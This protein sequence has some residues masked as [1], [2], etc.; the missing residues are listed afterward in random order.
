MFKR[1]LSITLAMIIAMSTFSTIS[2][3]ATQNTPANIKNTQLSAQGENSL[4]NMI[5]DELD[6]AMSQDLTSA[7]FSITGLT[8][9]GHTATVDYMSA[10]DCTI[11]VAL[12]DEK[13][14][15]M[16]ASGKSSVTSENDVATIN[17]EATLMPQY[18]VATAYML[19]KNNAPLT[20]EFTTELYTEDI[21]KVKEMKAT[22]FDEEL[23]LNLDDSD[24]TN[25]AVYSEDTKVLE[26][27]ENF[28]IPERI[29]DENGIYV[30]SNADEELKSLKKGD[31]FVYEYSI[32]NIFIFEVDTIEVNGDTV[33]ITEGEA[34]LEEVFDYVKIEAKQDT[35]DC[36][37]NMDG[38]DDDV[39]LIDDTSPLP[40]KGPASVG[41]EGDVTFEPEDIKLKLLGDADGKNIKITGDV[42]FGATATLEFYITLGKSYV[43][44]SIDY[45][46]DYTLSL[47]VKTKDTIEKPI[48]NINI[49]PIAGVVVS[50]TPTIV[51]EAQASISFKMSVG[52]K[53]GL[54]LSCGKIINTSEAPKTSSAIEAEGEM[55]VG[56]KIEPSVSIVSKKIFKLGLPVTGGFAL[57]VKPRDAKEHEDEKKGVK[58]LCK[59]CFE[60]T[61]TTKITVEAEV[62]VFNK[63]IGTVSATA[64]KDLFSFYFSPEIP[65]VGKGECP[66]YN[67]EMFTIEIYVTKGGAPYPGAEVWLY[68]STYGK[69]EGYTDNNGLITVTVPYDLYYV[70]VDDT[71]T[72]F[73]AN[74]E[75]KRV[76]LHLKGDPVP[77]EKVDPTEP[78]TPIPTFPNT[79]VTEP[80][81]TGPNII[82]TGVCGNNANWT[83]WDTGELSITGSGSI[84]DYTQDTIPWFDYISFITSVNINYGITHI[85]NY[86]FFGM[87]VD[88]I[89]IPVT[90]KS[91]GE[92][93]FANCNAFTSVS[94]PKNVETIGLYAF[95][96]CENLTTI[97]IP[98]NI[99]SLLHSFD[100]CNNLTTVNYYTDKYLDFLSNTLS[101][102]TVN[103]Y[104]DVP[105]KILQNCHN[106]TK[107]TFSDDVKNIGS[108]A[109]YNCTGITEIDLPAS[110]ETIKSAA[111]NKTGW[112]NNHPAGAMYLNHILYEYT[113]NE[114]EVEI[115]EG[116][117][118]I[119]QYAFSNCDTL[120]SVKIANGVEIIENSAFYTC[121][122][123]ESIELPNSLTNIGFYAFQ[124]CISLES[125]RIPD[126]VT[127]INLGAFYDCTSLSEV[128]LPDTL[129]RLEKV[130]FYGCSSLKTLKFPSKLTYIGEE[131]FAQCGLEKLNLKDNVSIKH[132]GTGAFWKCKNLSELI[133]PDNMT[134]ISQNMFSQCESLKTISLPPNLT[135][136]YYAAFSRTGLES[137]EFPEKLELIDNAAFEYTNI[138]S[139]KIPDSVTCLGQPRSIFLATPDGAFANC[140]NLA[141]IELGKNV[142]YIGANAFYGCLSLES[143]VI[144]NHVKSIY[145]HAFASCANLKTIEIPESV[146]LIDEHAFAECYSLKYAYIY[147]DPDIS[148]TAFDSHT[149]IYYLNHDDPKPTEEATESWTEDWS[150]NCTEAPTENSSTDPSEHCTQ[151]TEHSTEEPSEK[152]EEIA[153]LSYAKR[154][155][156]TNSMA[157]SRS[158]D[159][160]IKGAKYIVAVVKSDD[161]QDL[162][163]ADNLLY[164]KQVTADENGCAFVEYVPRENVDNLAELIFGAE[165]VN[166]SDS[167]VIVLKD[168][169]SDFIEYTVHLNGAKLQK[170]TDFELAIDGETV[171]ITGINDYVGTLTVALT[172]MIL[173]DVDNDNAITIMDATMIMLYLAELESLDDNQRIVANTDGDNVVS[174]LDATT[175]Q[176]LLASIITSF[177]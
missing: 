124:G 112:Y 53:V 10:I 137:I 156:T 42:G 1:F 30:F 145:N 87:P 106:I 166:I 84:Y 91:I 51:I 11:L 52:G 125:I 89:V 134:E 152:A 153:S 116:T 136:I 86:S 155:M 63:C 62:T 148:S 79:D 121:K 174:I 92:R 7:D 75:T 15:R 170:D 20:D 71:D 132:F 176:Q 162:L 99:E 88:E 72:T 147:G 4:G 102:K 57:A 2:V 55:F 50:F 83:F 120:K 16:S 6:E 67:V 17:I 13:T 171:T 97:D 172:P 3:S 22:D 36:E 34:E 58:H 164:I 64:K 127:C 76:Q 80:D 131:A 122:N 159:N 77:T 78:D 41:Y 85:G 26:Y 45:G 31:M 12:Y 143:Y 138:T 111:F 151:P 59:L 60:G 101:L 177:R 54:K 175:I 165:K 32:D 140:D 141:D 21:K 35:S 114:A 29:D 5:A 25:F 56:L 146:T 157:Y 9:E 61:V 149:K 105:D 49:S 144:P 48:M 27:K 126:N 130:A 139:I 69:M 128:R 167:Q 123:L 133:L 14:G 66:H 65:D 142:T 104:N 37:V 43:D 90:V 33:T 70:E 74:S 154:F 19:D 109:F 47:N 24:G 169:N 107:V 94:I 46:F 18:F 40:S 161:A 115:R 150:G 81:E 100:N 82:E 113:G 8:I 23:V 173:G 158:F 160:L 44:F 119:N 28:N 93:A 68:S 38:I 163:S 129:E 103:F 117:R 95:S 98:E 96:D 73:V 168:K 135:H 118:I 39:M 108:Y 110:V